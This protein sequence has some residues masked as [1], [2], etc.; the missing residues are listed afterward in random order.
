MISTLRSQVCVVFQLIL[1]SPAKLT[2]FEG[3]SAFVDFALALFPITIVWDLKL[4]MKK[5]VGLSVLL[6]LG[7]LW[8]FIP[9]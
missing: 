8:A 9:N 7:V 2:S 3:Y 6:G 4:S 1:C 5:R